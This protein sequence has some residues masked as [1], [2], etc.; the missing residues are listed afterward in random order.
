V[1]TAA[2]AVTSAIFGAQWDIAWHR[3]IG[4]DTFWSPPHMAIYACG[5]LGALTAIVLTFRTTFAAKAPLRDTSVRVWGFRAPL[6]AF[7]MAWGGVAM[8]TSAP[9]DD[10][11]HNAY[12]I[13]VK[14]I[15]PPHAVLAAGIGTVGV[16]SLLLVLGCMNRAEGELRARLERVF[17]YM[18]GMLLGFAM[19]FLMERTDRTEMHTAMFYR[20]VA[21]AAPL[22]LTG[23]GRA[24]GH[25]YGATVVAVV[26]SIFN[27]ALLWIFP[28]VP[29]TPKLGPV[30]YPVTHLVPPPF[31]LLLIVPALGMDLLARRA[32]GWSHWKHALACGLVFVG[33]FLAVQWPFAELLMH[34]WS[35]NRIFGTIYF[36]YNTRPSWAGFQHRF[37]HPRIGM[38]EQALTWLSAVVVSILGARLGLG[39]ASWMKRVK[40]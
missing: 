7:L 14:I 25:K 27:L 35:R 28:L 17:L 26:Y 40:R 16:G 8:L 9:F 10:W 29:A 33:L 23:I 36:D 37:W 21:L 20:D 1:V 3:S 32:Q 13:D 5:V 2:L 4:R 6:G 39:W 15:S 19:V 11:W 30:Y 22:I 12:G 38:A 24:S 34:P 31:P 18:G